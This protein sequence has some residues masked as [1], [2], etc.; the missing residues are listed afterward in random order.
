[1][2]WKI[3]RNLSHRHAYAGMF[4]IHTYIHAYI[5]I[6]I[7]IFIGLKTNLVILMRI[8]RHMI[9]LYMVYSGTGGAGLGRG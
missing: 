8:Y 9:M 1:M 7:Y 3:C 4:Y 6:Y 5:H 2:V